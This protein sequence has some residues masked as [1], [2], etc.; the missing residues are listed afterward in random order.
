MMN[1]QRYCLPLF[2]GATP[3]HQFSQGL[4][5]SGHGVKSDFLFAAVFADRFF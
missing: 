5:R 3:G 2:L 4:G 1:H